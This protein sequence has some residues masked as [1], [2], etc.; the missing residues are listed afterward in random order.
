MKVLTRVVQ[1][2]SLLSIE[3][4]LS[5]VRISNFE[6]WMKLWMLLSENRSFLSLAKRFN[7]DRFEWLTILSKRTY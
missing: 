4:L 5:D 2:T 1:E 3:R 6:I 7:L